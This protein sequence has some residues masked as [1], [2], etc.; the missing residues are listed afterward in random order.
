MDPETRVFQRADSKNLVIL[1]CTVF[2][3]AMDRQTD[4]Q[5]CDGQDALQQ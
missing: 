3:R 2:D 5:N 4:G 1:A